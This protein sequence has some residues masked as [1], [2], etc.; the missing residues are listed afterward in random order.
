[1]RK[2]ILSTFFMTCLSNI[3]KYSPEIL[4]GIGISGMIF[5]TIMA[6]RVTPAAMKLIEQKKNESKKD[7]LDKKEVVQTTWR[8]YTPSVVSTVVSVI[9]IIGAS[10]INSKRNTALAAAYSISESALKL[11]Q[12]KVIET[13]G[14]K[15]EQEVRDNVAKEY[16]K[17]D[18]IT[19]R[20]IILT[21]R[22]NTLCYDPLSS[23]YFKSDIEMLRQ[24]VN[25]LNRDM[26][27]RIGMS[28]SLNDFYDKIG[29][30][31]TT[32]GDS[33]G[34]NVNKGLIELKFSSQLTNNAMP[35]L[36]INFVTMPSYDFN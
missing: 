14:E 2:Q 35:C 21:E 13:V 1:M 9:C 6:V 19:T 5:S 18:P 10:T 16:L 32:V 22:G 26:T 3:K 8:C 31:R 24:A 4:T 36:V 33:I 30:D 17:N 34:W 27:I 20:E 23:R 12:E 7:R 11:Y 28:V 25:E 15:K 29:I